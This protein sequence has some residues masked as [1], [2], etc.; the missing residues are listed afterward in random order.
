MKPRVDERTPLKFNSYELLN[1]QH[2][3]LT[4][5]SVIV[6]EGV[7]KTY[8]QR[9]ALV[10]HRI[11]AGMVVVFVFIIP[12]IFAVYK[13]NSTVIDVIPRQ[14]ATIVPFSFVDPRLLG[15]QEIGRPE[16]SRPGPI[17]GDLRKM[18]VPLPTNSWCENL[19]LGGTN[20]GPMNNVFQLPY[21]IDSAGIFPVC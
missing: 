18:H 15:F 9:R 13:S 20:S 7:N 16:S 10:F 5:S 11:I 12:C 19:F 17:F 2:S 3:G 1:Q 21:I 6:T 14:E 4:P 8:E